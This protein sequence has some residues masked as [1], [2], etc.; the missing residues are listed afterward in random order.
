M[1]KRQCTVCKEYF[2]ATTDHFYRAANDRLGYRC[3]PCA[4]A[5]SVRRITEARRIAREGIEVI[6]RYT[7][8]HI[9]ET[10]AYREYHLKI[11][12]LRQRRYRAKKE[13]ALQSV[14][15][16]QGLINRLKSEWYQ[17]LVRGER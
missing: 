17:S 12:R 8:P 15:R 10:P 13:G 16:M 1:D 14:Q 9:T 6:P 5:E 4:N 2:E 3:K 11:T 7:P